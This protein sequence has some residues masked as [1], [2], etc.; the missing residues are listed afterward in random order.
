MSDRP[1]PRWRRRTAAPLVLLAGA[2]VLV[3]AGCGKSADQKANEAY[4]NSVC[5]AIGGWET[6]VKGIATDLSGGVSKAS[7]QSKATQAATAT[8]TLATQIKAVAPPDTSDG[9]AA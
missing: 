8:K 4:A 2:L 5:S 1:S 9:T 3:A 7:F 6:Q